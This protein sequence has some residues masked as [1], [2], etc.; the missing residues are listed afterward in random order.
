V[1]PESDY[2]WLFFPPEPDRTEP[3]DPFSV[4][5]GFLAGPENR[6]VETAVCWALGGIPFFADSPE[7]VALS[8]RIHRSKGDSR[9]RKG[10]AA[11]SPYLGVSYPIESGSGAV[12]PPIIDYMPMVNVPHFLPILFTGPSGSGKSL[13]AAGIFREY[14]RLHPDDRAIFLTGND[15]VRTYLQGVTIGTLSH[16]YDYFTA[17][18][19]VVLDAAEPIFQSE[20]A[21]DGLR[22]VLDICSRNGTLMLVTASEM[23]DMRQIRLEPLTARLEA[24][25]SI[26]FAYPLFGTRQ[27]LID[28]FAESYRLTLETAVR[29]FLAES[30]PASV[31]SMFGAFRQMAELFDWEN[32]KPSIMKI[33]HFLQQRDPKPEVEIDKIAKASARYYAVKVS[34]MRSK[35]RHKTVVLAR[36]MTIFL[37][38]K[39]IGS[40]YA[41]LGAWFAGR[42]H[43][44]IL[45]GGREIERKMDA[46]REL[47]A[48]QTAILR[49][50]KIES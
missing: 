23:P 28:T 21:S 44:T 31:G 32:Q 47:A 36:N 34:D 17:G 38:R 8:E 24:G 39:L 6:L 42:D 14:L 49:E 4:L 45:H 37:A 9:R 25:L 43:T 5:G 19:L 7:S 10:F 15:F 13:V 50:L 3:S 41:E 48:A 12:F 18:K 46:D 11:D 27:R 33:R 2:H 20:A 35:S 16:F 40:T 26:R 22:T 29:D 1:T 30:L